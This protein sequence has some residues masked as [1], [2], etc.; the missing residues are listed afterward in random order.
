VGFAGRDQS[1]WTP[2][3]LVLDAD[4]ILLGKDATDEVALSDLVEGELTDLYNAISGATCTPN[5]GG[6]AFKNAIIAALSGW[7]G[8]TAAQKV[9][10]E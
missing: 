8:S 5:D 6:L 2:T 4:E 7:P 9:K 3:Q 10:A 1:T